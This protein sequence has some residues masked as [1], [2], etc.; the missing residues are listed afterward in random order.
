[1]HVL[2]VEDSRTTASQLRAALRAL[3]HEA[4]VV[5]NG[6]LA[7][8]K[9]GEDRSIGLVL[10][11]WMMPELDG[12]GLIRALKAAEGESVPVALMSVIDAGVAE[13]NALQAGAIAYLGKPVRTSDLERLL[14]S[15][16]ARG[17][18]GQEPEA[19]DIV[20][21]TGLTIIL[22]GTL[23][24]PD[25]ATVLAPL[26]GDGRPPVLVVHQGP[27]EASRA[28]LARAGDLL[29]REIQAVAGTASLECGR[30]YGTSRDCAPNL[31]PGTGTLRVG[32][33]QPRSMFTRV[34]DPLFKNA[35]AFHG[36]GL[37]IL[38]LA[39]DGTDGVTG[40]SVAARSGARILAADPRY[41]GRSSLVR[42]LLETV[43]GVGLG[44]YA[45]LGKSL[46]A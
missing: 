41:H 40:I 25:L 21:G 5:A 4:S 7:L 20:A 13:T 19:A 24:G 6:A 22:S 1:M 42:C 12:L 38:A 9:L 23:L 43:T 39:G 8:E 2:I 3:G 17:E 16:G 15:L 18:L 44:R 26:A 45:E 30:L 36:A 37:G 34:L 28:E 46:A 10:S 32:K 35:G 14:R 11:D 31:D 33:A 29:G 27:W